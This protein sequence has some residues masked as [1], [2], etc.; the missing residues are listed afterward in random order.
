MDDGILSRFTLFCSELIFTCVTVGFF[1]S[2][3]FGLIKHYLIGKIRHNLYSDSVRIKAFRLRHDMIVTILEIK[4][5][6]LK[7]L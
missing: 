2:T 6:L 4:L 7:L 3:C 5:I 1:N